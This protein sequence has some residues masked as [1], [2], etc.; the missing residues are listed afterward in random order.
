M[1]SWGSNPHPGA[2][3]A[4][5]AG[6][7]PAGG[8]VRRST[9]VGRLFVGVSRT[10]TVPASPRPAPPASRQLN[11]VGLADTRRSTVSDPRTEVTAVLTIT[12]EPEQRVVHYRDGRLVG[13]LEPGRYRRRRRSRYVPVDIRQQLTPTAPQEVLTSDGVSVKVSAT[14]RWAIT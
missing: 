12:V 7:R 3:A 8:R 2:G 14:V 11:P 1:V 10:G 4:D 5:Q 13:V 6:G 9:P